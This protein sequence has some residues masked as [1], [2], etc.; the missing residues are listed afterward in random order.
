V[1][2]NGGGQGAGSKLS[3]DQAVSVTVTPVNDAPNVSAPTT[4]TV[5]EDSFATQPTTIADVDDATFTCAVVTAASH[6]SVSFGANCVSVTYTTTQLNYNGA[7]SFTF[8]VTDNGGGQGAGSKLSD[9]QAVSVTITAVPDAPICNNINVTV[10]QNT[11]KALT[12]DCSD[13]DVGDTL[14][15]E[16]VANPSHGDLTGTAPNLTYT[17][18]SGYTG[19]DSFTYRAKDNTDRYS[20]TVTASITVSVNPPPTCNNINVTTTADTPVAVNLNCTDLAGDPLTYTIVSNPS[21]GALS[22]TAP[23]LTYTPASGYTGADSFTYKAN[24]GVSDSNIATVSITVTTVSPPA[25]TPTPTT[26]AGATPTP[27]P[28]PTVA[29][30]VVETALAA[31]VAAGSKEICVEDAEGFSAGDTIE[32]GSGD[33]AE[34]R[35]ITAVSDA[36][37]TLDSALEFDHT[38]GEAVVL[39]AVA[40]S[41]PTPAE[42]CA[43]AFPGTYN[44][45]VRLDG[46]PAA[47]GLVL[48]ALLGDTEWASTSVTGGL[49]VLDIPEKLPSQPPCF[50]GGTITFKLNGAVCDQTP[51]WAAGLHDLDV[52]CQTPPP[53]VTPVVTPTVP[54]TPPPPGITPTPGAIVTPAALPPTGAGGLLGGGSAPWTAAVAAGGVLALLLTAVGL[55]RGARRRAR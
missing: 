18:D 6:G 40:T 26:T 41:T 30:P 1:T 9:D 15:Y 39:A 53:P 49:Y 42:I 17:P 45:T 7:D 27:T 48:K 14:T 35:T 13:P 43:P 33:T 21:H 31:D 52:T 28:T 25:P 38:A 34:T 37:F 36:C 2:D 47:D 24:D 3:D 20:D 22:G 8:R 29:P 19:A 5:A 55:S 16:I 46:V 12:L 54:A 11:A 32:I 44:G 10:L 4:M 51:E 50:E 23:N